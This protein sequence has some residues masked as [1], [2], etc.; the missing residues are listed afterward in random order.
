MTAELSPDELRHLATIGWQLA[1]RRAATGP[2][3]SNQE[4]MARP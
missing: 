4:E 3:T 1:G 2:A